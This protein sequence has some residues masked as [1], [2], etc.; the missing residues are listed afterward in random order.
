MMTRFL[1][2]LLL[3]SLPACASTS[4]PH[5]EPTGFAI[6]RGITQVQTE[7]GLPDVISDRSGDQ[8]R[9]YPATD[10]P[11]YEW[12][13]DAPRTF[14]YLRQ[15]V[16][17]TFVLGRLTQ[18]GAI[19]VEILSVLRRVTGMSSPLLLVNRKPLPE[20]LARRIEARVSSF[21]GPP[22]RLVMHL[23]AGLL[24]GVQEGQHVIQLD[25]EKI[26][27]L[28]EITEVSPTAASARVLHSAEAKEARAGSIVWVWTGPPRS[29]CVGM[30]MSDGDIHEAYTRTHKALLE[31]IAASRAVLNELHQQ[32]KADEIV[33]AH[34]RILRNLQERLVALE[35]AA[36]A[37]DPMVPPLK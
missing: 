7:H 11:E 5:I 8:E 14:Y 31:T 26:L 20:S 9:F 3:S 12:P 19:D 30:V 37:F 15:N 33:A 21:T 1:V 34:R 35:E 18:S 24:A 2:I 25:D 29:C 36:L 27:R 28:A 22:D 6:G 23:D 32:D 17:A 10:R 16:Q 13:A 4:P